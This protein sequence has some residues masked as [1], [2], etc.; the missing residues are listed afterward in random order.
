MQVA[1]ESVPE[2]VPEVAAILSG[3]RNNQFLISV[4]SVLTFH[5]GI[6]VNYLIP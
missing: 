5:E 3:C 6:V 2:V 4:F 1:L